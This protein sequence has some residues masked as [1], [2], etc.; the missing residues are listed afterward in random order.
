MEK[1]EGGNEVE[2]T[3]TA[4]NEKVKYFLQHAKHTWLYSGLLQAHKG[5]R[6]VFDSSGFSTAGSLI[7]ASTVSYYGG[8]AVVV[9]QWRL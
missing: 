6:T 8:L 4:K 9:S 1:T 5:S 3:G 7:S 2:G